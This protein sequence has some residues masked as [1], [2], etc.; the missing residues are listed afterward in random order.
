MSVV[1]GA[2]TADNL[3][4]RGVELI[5]IEPSLHLAVLTLG[6]LACDH[7]GVRCSGNVEDRLTARH[8][9]ATVACRTGDEGRRRPVG[10]EHVVTVGLQHPGK[11]GEIGS[12]E[13]A[14]SPQRSRSET[15]RGGDVER[16]E[17]RIDG[18]SITGADLMAGTDGLAVHDDQVHRLERDPAALDQ[19][20]D[21]CRTWHVPFHLTILSSEVVV[22]LGVEPKGH[23][24]T[25]RLTLEAA[26]HGPLQF[27]GPRTTVSVVANPGFK[28]AGHLR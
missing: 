12:D 15:N 9:D 6:V 18:H 20:A 25:H 2:V 1:M 24:C 28:D 26:P 21:R 17:H 4:P 10:G 11:R 8:D 5:E 14:G 7:D 19:G 23:R 3:A 27:C 13:K 16:L 22:E